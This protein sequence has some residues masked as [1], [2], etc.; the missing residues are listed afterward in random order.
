MRYKKKRK[1]VINYIIDTRLPK[2]CP[3]NS[4]TD[5]N[6]SALLIY[7]LIARSFSIIGVYHQCETVSSQQKICVMPTGNTH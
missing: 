2:L 6:I 1:K 4:E 5:S 3:V 7:D